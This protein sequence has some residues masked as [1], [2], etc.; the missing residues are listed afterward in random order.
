MASSDNN[1]LQ[2][3]RILRWLGSGT[4]N[5]FGWPY[6]GKDT[7]CE[8]LGAWLHGPVLSGGDLMRNAKNLASHMRQQEETGHLV[9]QAGYISFMTPYLQSPEFAGKPL[10]LSSVGRW[11]GEE[12]PIMDV[13]IKAD[14][15]TKCVIYIDLPER[16]IRQR[17]EIAHADQ[18]RA[19]R[20]DHDAEVLETRM[21]EF[22]NKTLPVIEVYRQKGLLET[23]D[24]SGT[25]DEVEA[26]IIAV[27][28]RRS[29]EVN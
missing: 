20:A 15:P 17:F 19:T 14:H 24:G 22:T 4:I 12:G 10:I 27:L 1:L 7:Q 3:Q 8:R 29:T 5:V 11:I 16:I 2:K 21:Q 28:D 26:H 9:D 23:V 18:T 6:A 25:I 13:L